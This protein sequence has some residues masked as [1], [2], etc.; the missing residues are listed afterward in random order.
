MPG[1]EQTKAGA[2]APLASP[3]VRVELTLDEVAALLR[4]AGTRALAAWTSHAPLPPRSEQQ[5][6]A[7]SAYEKMLRALQAARPQGA[8]GA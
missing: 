3:L 7:R 5:E 6:L 2:P 8:D 1:G 4:D